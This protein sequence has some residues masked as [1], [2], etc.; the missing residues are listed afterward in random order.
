MILAY[1]QLAL[2]MIL[3]GAN[4]GVAKLLADALPIAMIACLRCLLAVVV[5]WPLARLIEGRVAVPGAVKHNLFLQAVFGTAIYNAGLLAGLRFTSALEGG[6]VLATLPAVVALGSFLWLRERLSARQWLAAGL[7]GFGM[8]AITLARLGGGS[9]GSALGNLLVFLGV[10]GEAIYVLLARRVAGA[11]PVITASLWMQ[12]FSAVFLLPFA[13]P[14]YASVAALA[15]PTLLA[16]LLFHSLTAS[17][18][19]LLLWYAGMKRVPAATA[20]V[21]TAFLPAS[22]AVTAVLFLGEGFGLVHAAGFA[23]M[24]TSLLLATWPGRGNS[25]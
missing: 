8:A 4:V 11:V 1:G 21:F 24:M 14:G 15:D 25:R 20:G 7:A 12:A 6:L 22:A 9:G 23:L 5:L 17:V 19:C 16:L 2:A 3:V 13:A 18:L 10:C